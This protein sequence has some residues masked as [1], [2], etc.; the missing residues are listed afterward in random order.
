MVRLFLILLGIVAV[1]SSITYLLWR[2]SP[3]VKL[4]KY[5]PALV[6]LLA[7]VYYLYI[8]KTIHVG[9]ADLANMIISL[10]FLTG[11]ASGLATSLLLDFVVPRSKSESKDSS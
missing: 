1:F 11:F 6:C 7:G 8:A 4:V 9:F 10:M 3:R 2:V 5:S